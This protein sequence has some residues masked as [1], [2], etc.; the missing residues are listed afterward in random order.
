VPALVDAREPAAKF[1]N[2][3]RL[4]HDAGHL[5]LPVFLFLDG[6]RVSREDNN[7]AFETAFEEAMHEIEPRDT[8][9][10]VI[11]DDEIEGNLRFLKKLQ[12]FVP[13]RGEGGMMA[14]E[15]QD[16]RERR[17]GAGLVINDEDIEDGDRGILDS[18][19]QTNRAGAEPAQSV[20]LGNRLLPGE[21]I[22]GAAVVLRAGGAALGVIGAETAGNDTGLD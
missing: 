16:G 20:E 2:I 9:H 22:V 4:F 7:L 10:H 1:H 18:S 12:R 14:G 19:D 5:E 15:L 3:E 21:D 13:I 17:A 11:G 6:R 8:D